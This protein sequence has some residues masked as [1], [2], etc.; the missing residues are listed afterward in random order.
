MAEVDVYQYGHRASCE[1][2]QDYAIERFL[3]AAL[4]G[5]TV[6]TDDQAGDAI[7]GTRERP[8]H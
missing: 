3:T 6:P 5:A 4:R 8:L 2:R 1:R 7:Q